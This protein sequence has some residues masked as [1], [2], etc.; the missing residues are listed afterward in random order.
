MKRSEIV[1]IVRSPDFPANVRDWAECDEYGWSIAHEAANEW[2]LPEGFDQWEIAYD[3]S[4]TVAHVAARQGSLPKGFDKWDLMEEYGWS[5]AHEAARFGTLPE[6]FDRWDIGA[7]SGWAVAHEA[8]INGTLPKGFDKWDMTTDYGSTVY[9]IA[10]KY[11]HLPKGVRAERKKSCSRSEVAERD[12]P[13]IKEAAR[14]LKKDKSSYWSEEGALAVVRYLE[15]EAREIQ[16]EFE[17]SAEWIRR[18]FVEYRNEEEVLSETGE[19]VDEHAEWGRLVAALDNG[20]FI[21][22]RTQ[23]VPVPGEHG[24]LIK[25][26]RLRKC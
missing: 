19:S 26:Q 3:K 25:W 14:M 7:G 1:A 15:K 20:G 13:G 16:E 2:K 11:G 23:P 5:V 21:L 8:A 4:F 17:F 10:K 6:D 22:K 24:L 9:D 12:R 18:E